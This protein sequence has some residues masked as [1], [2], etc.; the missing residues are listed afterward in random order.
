MLIKKFIHTNFF[1][2]FVL[3]FI[4]VRILLTFLTPLTADEAY[5]L[6]WSAHPAL[7]Y[8]DHPGMVAWINSI[9]ISIFKEPLLAIRLASW[10]C[11]IVSLIFVYKTIVYLTNNRTKALYGAIL[12]FLIPYNFIFALTMQVDQPLLM[13]FSIAIYFS[14]KYIKE[15]H[16]KYLYILTTL[17]GLAFLS[18]YMIVIPI[19]TLFIYLLFHKR[20]L[21]LNKHF[22]YAIALFLFIISPIFIWNYNNNWIS[23]GFHASRIGTEPLFK[24]FFEYILEQFLYITPMIW[25]ILFQKRDI[26]KREQEKIVYIIFI[27]VML[28]FLV[29][30]IKTKIWAHWTS[31]AYYPLCV[32]LASII[33]ENKLKRLIIH[34]M[35]FITLL[36]LALGFTGPRVFLDQ[37]KFSENKL[38]ETKLEKETNLKIKDI[39]VFSDFHGACGEL[40]YYLKKQVYMPTEILN[41]K[42]G[43]GENQHK[44]WQSR[45]TSN[46]SEPILVFASAH[47]ED[48]LN[49]HYKNVKKLPNIKMYTIEGHIT[50]K[51]FYLCS[52]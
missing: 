44:L 16:P 39:Q 2:L 5:Y 9:F 22:L 27:T 46:T 29:F 14:F 48:A 32:Y 50:S 52:N 19:I 34:L 36:V 18:K 23:F 30:S 8:I 40:S 45:I 12:Y 3:F 51:S 37:A 13:F 6:Q 1:L 47:F 31:L 15:S 21:I 41:L 25:I 4:F 42:G 10:S 49:S 20:K 38:L 26:N 43:W 35:I 17:F 24:S 28:F 11:L 33:E 7:S